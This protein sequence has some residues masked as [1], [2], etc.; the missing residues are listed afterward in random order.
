M[1]RLKQIIAFCAVTVVCILGI[2]VFVLASAASAANPIPDTGQTTSYTDTFGE[3]ADYTIKPPSYTKLDAQGNA[4]Q[5]SAPSWS[6]V[7]DNVTGLIWENK[8]DDGSIHDKDDKYN[9][10]NATSRFIANLNTNHFGG[11]SDWRLPTVKEL[12]VIVNR[13]VYVP[14]VNKDYFPN[15]M[16]SNYWSSTSCADGTLLYAWCVDFSYGSVNDAKRTVSCFV[17]AVRGA[18]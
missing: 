15:T 11:F 16:G 17:R 14:S 8:T 12:S 18:Q 3:D 7:R 13:G 5:G 6:M 2:S 10:D 4:L 1:I 9:W